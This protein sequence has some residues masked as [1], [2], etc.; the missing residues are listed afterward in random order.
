MAVVFYIILSH[1]IICKTRA[2]SKGVMYSVFYFCFL[3]LIYLFVHF[4]YVFNH[5]IIFFIYFPCII[6]TDQKQR[7]K[8]TI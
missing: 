3:L 2:G 5:L 7:L 8:G 6:R 4:I 1:D